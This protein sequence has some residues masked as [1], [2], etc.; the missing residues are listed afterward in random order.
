[1]KRLMVVLA[2]LTSAYLTVPA[3]LPGSAQAQAPGRGSSDPR[4]ATNLFLVT[5]TSETRAVNGRAVVWTR[6][7]LAKPRSG[8]GLNH[9]QW[10]PEYRITM[11]T[12]AGAAIGEE[13]TSG[14]LH[15]NNTQ[16]Y[17]I[18]G[19][20]GSVL[21]EGAVDKD[22]EYLVA[23][24]EH[25]GGPIVGGRRVKVKEGDVLSIPPFTWHVAYGDPGQTLTYMMV[26]VHTPQTIP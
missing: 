12:R 21:V 8:G 19:G 26:H 16:I 7:E 15:D 9:I 5:G 13:P 18:T 20:K 24:G 6:E 3:S 10:T 14:E 23:P 25:R 22:H 11:T 4:A 17:V 1:M 2:A